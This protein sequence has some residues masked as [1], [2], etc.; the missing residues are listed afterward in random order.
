MKIVNANLVLIP[1]KAYL[2]NEHLKEGAEKR[3]GKIRG[4]GGEVGDWGNRIV[5]SCVMHSPTHGCARM[6]IHR[7][8]GDIL[9]ETLGP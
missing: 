1:V 9:F 5:F 2:Q 4:K 8:N 6:H 3:Q 7:I